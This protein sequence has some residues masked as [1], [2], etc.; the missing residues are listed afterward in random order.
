MRDET[1]LVSLS[2][3]RIHRRQAKD[4]RPKITL[5]GIVLDIALGDQ[6]R[7]FQSRLRFILG[8]AIFRHFGVII[9]VPAINI[10]GRSE[11]E[12]RVWLHVSQQVSSA[13]DISAETEFGV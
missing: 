6:L 10:L 9:C 3:L 5:S 2:W 7:P 4:A 1:A 8:G 12:R 11:D 13:F